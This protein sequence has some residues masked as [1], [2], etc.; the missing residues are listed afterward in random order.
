M[1]LF[2]KQVPF[3]PK[4]FSDLSNYQKKDLKSLFTNFRDADNLVDLLEKMLEYNH[5]VRI[6]AKEA[7]SHPFFNEVKKKQFIKNVGDSE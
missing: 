5:D 2:E 4:I 3:D 7:L 1:C 6:S